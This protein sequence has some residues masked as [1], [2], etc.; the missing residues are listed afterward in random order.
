M[1]VFCLGSK[2]M[3]IHGN[4]SFNFLFLVLFRFLHLLSLNKTDIFRNK[5]HDYWSP[6]LIDV[7]YYSFI[8]NTSDRMKIFVSLSITYWIVMLID[9]HRLTS[10]HD[11]Q[12]PMT[13]T[14]VRNERWASTDNEWLVNLFRKRTWFVY[15]MINKVSS[16][17]HLRRWHV[18][19]IRVNID[20]TYDDDRHRNVQLFFFLFSFKT[21]ERE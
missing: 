1:F 2:E 20:R 6:S 13:R 10:K 9:Q 5:Q 17:D 14:H 12:W 11:Q 3:I 18:F 4:S 21:I 19:S 7:I 15:V 8:F 16:I